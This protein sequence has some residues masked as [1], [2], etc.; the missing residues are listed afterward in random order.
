MIDRNNNHYL[1]PGHP[2]RLVIYLNRM[3][4][5]ACHRQPERP[6]KVL[7]L[8]GVK[9]PQRVMTG[10]FRFISTFFRATF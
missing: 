2:F 6:D 5:I 9:K 10:L 1:Q 7:L 8:E 3:Y 4:V